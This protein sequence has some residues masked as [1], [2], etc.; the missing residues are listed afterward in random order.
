LSTEICAGLFF[1]RDRLNESPVT[2]IPGT[3]MWDESRCSTD[4]GQG[5]AQTQGTIGNQAGR[6][7]SHVMGNNG[8]E[9]LSRWLMLLPH[10]PSG[11]PA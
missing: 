11:E 10:I 6:N 8:T 7:W 4:C 3:Q 5:I 2:L 9:C 1:G